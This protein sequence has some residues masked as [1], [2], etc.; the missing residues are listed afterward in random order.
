MP[1]T[2]QGVSPLHSPVPSWHE[3]VCSPKGGSAHQ[4]EERLCRELEGSGSRR[5]A[6]GRAGAVVWGGVGCLYSPELLG[7]VPWLCTT[8]Q[9]VVVVVV[10]KIQP[11]PRSFSKVKS[12]VSPSR[13]RFGNGGVAAH[14]FLHKY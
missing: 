1:P 4:R 2:Y 14:L 7:F 13:G 6:E 9:A 10:V 3:G 11:N 5:G 8:E 12:G